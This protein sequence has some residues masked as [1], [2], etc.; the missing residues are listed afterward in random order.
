MQ[1]Y[2]S[3]KHQGL[4]TASVIDI[5]LPSER[6]Y[7]SQK[8]QDDMK[9]FEE[10]RAERK[11]KKITPT[12]N[13]DNSDLPDR[14]T[15]DKDSKGDPQENGSSDESSSSEDLGEAYELG[16]GD[17]DYKAASKSTM[18]ALQGFREKGMLD[19]DKMIDY[20]GRSNDVKFHKEMDRLGVDNQEDRVKLEYRDKGGRLMTQKQAFRYF[21]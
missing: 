15:K 8:D 21:F 6:L 1:K 16:E 2:L 11:P 18:F 12:P 17:M 7:Q 19:R 10:R 14:E 3:L 5:V 9:L 13:P 20:S 4:G